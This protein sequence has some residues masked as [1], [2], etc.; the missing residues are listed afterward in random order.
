MGKGEAE[1][2]TGFG[3]GDDGCDWE[4]SSGCTV[5]GGPLSPVCG[6]SDLSTIFSIR[7]KR[8]VRRVIGCFEVDVCIWVE[9]DQPFD[10]CTARPF[11]YL[12]DWSALG[13]F[14][15]G[16]FIEERSRKVGP[17]AQD[18]AVVFGLLLFWSW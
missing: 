4:V 2:R 14:L 10:V 3:V 15:R 18:V 12:F 11:R 7:L 17:R 6:V 9:G 13:N 5:K 8:L 1:E 16:I